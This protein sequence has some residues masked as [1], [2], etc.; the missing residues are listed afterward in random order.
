MHGRHKSNQNS[1]KSRSLE[2]FIHASETLPPL[3]FYGTTKYGWVH[4]YYEKNRTGFEPTTHSTKN[5]PDWAD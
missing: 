5:K 4:M 3:S 2:T 1:E